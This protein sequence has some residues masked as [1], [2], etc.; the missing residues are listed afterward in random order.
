MD[1]K[2]TYD[3]IAED[4]HK[5]HLNDDWWKVVTDQF[6]SL[7]RVGDHVLDVGCGSGIKSKYLSD[8][9]L[10]V[11]GID[12]SD[13]MVEI[14]KREFPQCEFKALDMNKVDSLN[15]TFDHVFAQAALLHIPR[16]EMEQTLKNLLKVLKPGGYLYVGV[17]DKKPGKGD[18]GVLIEDDYG[19][20]YSRFFSY[21][22]LPELKKYFSDLNLKII[23]ENITERGRATWVQIIGQKS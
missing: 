20:T 22:S 5:D 16:K 7:C 23:L 2:S 15:M 19:Y 4:W 9:G 14:A 17:K 1:L 21:H 13:K 12:I 6:I 8:H 18:E 10:K 3:L 11:T